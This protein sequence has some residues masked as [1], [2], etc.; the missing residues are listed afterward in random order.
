[1]GEKCELF[2]RNNI[3]STNIP[4][5]LR[6]ELQFACNFFYIRKIR[7]N[8]SGNQIMTGEKMKFGCK[9][10]NDHVFFLS[11]FEHANICDEPTESV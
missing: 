4:Y 9:K 11:C 3:A 8:G 2:Y 10:T 5:A 6:D 7:N 1:M